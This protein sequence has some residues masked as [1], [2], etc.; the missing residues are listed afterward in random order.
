M[1]LILCLLVLAGSSSFAAK[2]KPAL[3]TSTE[4]AYPLSC[5]AKA[6]PLVFEGWNALANARPEEARKLLTRAL[7]ADP[8]C[9]MARASLSLFGPAG[10][11]GVE[12]LGPVERLHLKALVAYRNGDFERSFVLT[13]QLA[14]LAPRVMV[15]NLS[16]AQAALAA[17]RWNEAAAAATK[18]TELTPLNGAGWFLLGQARLRAGLTAEANAAFRKYAEVAPTEANA[19]DALGDVLLAQGELEAAATSYQRAIDRSEGKQWRAWSGLASVLALSGSWSSARVAIATWRA[20]ASQPRDQLQA[21][22]MLAWSY[23]AQGRL[24]EALQ[25]AGAIRGAPLLRGELLLA[26]GKNAEAL[27]AFRAARGRP[28]VSRAHALA[29]ITV[30]QARLGQTAA[31]AQS[32]RQLERLGTQ[33][34]VVEQRAWARGALALAQNAPRRA[35]ESLSACSEPFDACRLLYIEALQS[36]GETAEALEARAQLANTHRRDPHSWFIHEQL[37]EAS[38]VTSVRGPNPPAR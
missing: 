17:G 24:T 38:G 18:A 34:G 30:A 32:L 3:L 6:T 33:P 11:L 15:V 8:R 21:D 19:H 10:P 36:A 13:Q 4:V 25:I 2:R 29:D 37:K 7:A 9:V 27:L 1:R 22:V 35:L 20:A 31:A 12:P 26:S 28:G 5:E 14:R 23:A 16:A